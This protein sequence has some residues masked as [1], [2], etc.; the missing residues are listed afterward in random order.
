MMVKVVIAL[1][2]AAL[3]H[4]TFFGIG[5]LIWCINNATKSG[6]WFWRISS[7]MCDRINWLE[8]LSATSVSSCR[9]VAEL[10]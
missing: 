2:P 6:D 3:F 5:L 7:R 4:V 8:P 1:T 9:A 10:S